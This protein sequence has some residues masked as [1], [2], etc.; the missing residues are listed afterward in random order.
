MA[1]TEL[2]LEQIDNATPE[3][4]EAMM[5]QVNG[6]DTSGED[7]QTGQEPNETTQTDE[8]STDGDEDQGENQDEPT[9][10][11]RLAK[12]EE[13]NKTL[14]KRVKD[15]DVFIEQRNAEIGKMRKQ[16]RD[17]QL[18]EM[19]DEV[20]VNSDEFFDDPVKATQA[21]IEAKEKK[22][23][24]LEEEETEHV[25]QMKS[26]LKQQVLSYEPAYEEKVPGIIEILK[27]DEAPAEIIE[28][29]KENP[30]SFFNSAVTLQLVKRNILTKRVAELE[31]QLAEAK[32]EPAKIIA[33]VNQYGKN[34]S[35]VT[36]SRPA[37]KIGGKDPMANLTQKDI[38]NMS[39]E[40]LAEL[41]KQVLRK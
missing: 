19:P 39:Y 6:N 35:K 11:E 22:K 38:D 37:A 21:I 8:T 18:A 32:G 14:S 15:K 7:Q 31:A 25:E 2:T 4:L 33:K 28:K 1:N 17:K 26:K 9:L 24:L 30:Y 5:E 3:E 36:T 12:L 29:F 23:A 20:D 40:E 13:D 10:E 34:K 27:A 41:E 16:I